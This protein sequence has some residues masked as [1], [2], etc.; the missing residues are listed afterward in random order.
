ME[1]RLKIMS[2]KEEIKDQEAYLM[3]REKLGFCVYP[4]CCLHF[5]KGC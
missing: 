3:A 5:L 4:V 2:Y 1:K